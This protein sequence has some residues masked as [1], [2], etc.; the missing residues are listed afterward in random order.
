MNPF[1][2]V[3]LLFRVFVIILLSTVFRLLSS[4]F[5]LLSSVFRLLSSVFR[6]PSSVLC[7]TSSFSRVEPFDNLVIKKMEVFVKDLDEANAH[8]GEGTA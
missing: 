3:F 7:Y 6:H 5:R 4:V 1:F 2:F 8:I